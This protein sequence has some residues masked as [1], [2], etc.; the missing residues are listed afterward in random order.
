MRH[1]LSLLKL[2]RTSTH[3]WA[4]FRNMATSLVEAERVE[5]TLKKAKE[6]R[7]FA[8]YL[9]TLG[10]KN[11]LAA[12]RNALSFLRSKK[13]VQKLFGEIAPRFKDR[14]GGY[15][16]V[17]KL[18]FRLGDSAPMALIEYLSEAKK[19]TAPVGPADKK[20]AGAKKGK[21]DTKGRAKDK[22]TA[23]KKAASAKKGSEKKKSDKK[24]PAKKKATKTSK[25]KS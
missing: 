9:I 10:K 14:N 19:E 20:K 23:P 4:M 6:L 11:D 21:E 24:E 22:E 25:K 18:G 8:D 12:R 16:R 7:S 13:A 3:R 1:Q 17:L 15:T 2:G 5:T